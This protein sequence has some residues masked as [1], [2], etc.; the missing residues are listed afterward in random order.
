MVQCTTVWF[1]PETCQIQGDY[2]HTF[3]FTHLHMQSQS[4]THLACNAPNAFVRHLI[5]VAA[6]IGT[7]PH[8]S[9]SCRCFLRE[10]VRWRTLER[11]GANR[12]VMD[13]HAMVWK[14][15][16]SGELITFSYCLS[17]CLQEHIQSLHLYLTQGLEDCER[18]A[19]Q[20][21]HR[22]SPILELE[23]LASHIL[24]LSRLYDNYIPVYSI[25]NNVPGEICQQAGLQI[26]KYHF[27]CRYL[28]K[29]KS[30]RE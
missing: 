6:C 4:N 15:P 10:D 3:N 20:T 22:A 11:W 30:V 28:W 2:P 8:G 19:C 24:T 12:W 13:R 5:Y 1:V 17:S 7:E 23:L 25:V 27:Y 14:D 26:F 18:L 9:K 29:L 21:C 16:T